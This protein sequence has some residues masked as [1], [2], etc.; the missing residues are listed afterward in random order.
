MFD[1][2]VVSVSKQEIQ[3]RTDSSRISVWDV[4]DDEEEPA[5]FPTGKA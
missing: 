1:E 3:V 4:D 2:S 5:T